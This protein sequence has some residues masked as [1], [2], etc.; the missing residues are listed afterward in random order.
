M[1][2]GPNTE[3]RPASSTPPTMVLL[4]CK[5]LGYEE[6]KVLCDKEKVTNIVYASL[7]LLFSF[8]F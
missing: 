5:E 3:P 8:L 2:N 4:E 1:T 6:D 7:L